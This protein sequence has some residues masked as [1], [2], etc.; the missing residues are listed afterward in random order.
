MTSAA[1]EPPTARHD[2]AQAASCDSMPCSATSYVRATARRPS[3]PQTDSRSSA[4]LGRQ[5]ETP[6][7]TAHSNE[8]TE[9]TTAWT[10]EEAAPSGESDAPTN[11]ILFDTKE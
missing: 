2:D 7:G 6:S 9:K 1:S 8:R 3:H 10:S 4:A 5:S 11:E